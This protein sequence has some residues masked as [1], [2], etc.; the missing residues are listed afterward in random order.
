MSLIYV[1]A[2][3]NYLIINQLQRQ[4]LALYIYNISPMIFDTAKITK[5]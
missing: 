5:K 4:K 2:N 1:K 3:Y